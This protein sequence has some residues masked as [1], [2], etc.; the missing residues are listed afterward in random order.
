MKVVAI[1]PAR[2]GS[3]SLPRKNIRVVGGRPLIAHSIL[4]ALGCARIERTLVS[5]DDPEIAAIARE[6][7]AEVPFLRPTEFAR[8]DSTDLEVLFHALTWMKNNEQ[9]VP[10]LVVYLRPTEP[11]R[12]VATVEAAIARLI[13]HPAADSLRSVRVAQQTPYK[14]WRMASD[15]LEPAAVLEGVAEAYNQ[16]RQKLPA[17]YWQDGYVDVIRAR[18]IIE[19]RSSTGKKVLGFLISEPAINI[20]YEDELAA[21]DL[22]LRPSAESAAPTEMRHPA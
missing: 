12:R 5:T 7:G 10:D 6:H 18:T 17:V 21:A 3:K 16:P 14:M 8:D 13:D 4:T 15:W 11:L 2:G 19:Q 1:I 9:A 20:D 22:L